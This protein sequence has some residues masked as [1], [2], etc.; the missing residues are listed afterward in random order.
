MP[1]ESEPPETRLEVRRYTLGADIIADHA[2]AGIILAE[3]LRCDHEGIPLPVLD[4][5]P[6]H[7][8]V[9][10]ALVCVG[11]IKMHDASVE[12][13]RDYTGIVCRPAS[14]AHNRHLYSCLAE[15]AED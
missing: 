12:R 2:G 5:G 10:P 9:T 15:R 11:G 8:L 13:R 14:H 7:R 6:D 4:D 3:K 1:S